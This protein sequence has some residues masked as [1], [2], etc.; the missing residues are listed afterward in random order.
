MIPE[1]IRQLAAA[2]GAGG[3]GICIREIVK[4]HEE[5]L[6]RPRQWRRNANLWFDIE[7]AFVFASRETCA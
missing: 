4:F 5:L 2:F 6:R 7:Y 3:S 1:T